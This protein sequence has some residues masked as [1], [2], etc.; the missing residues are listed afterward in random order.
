MYEK[1][2]FIAWRVWFD[3]FKS[4]KIS[5]DQLL[6]NAYRTMIKLEVEDYSR[7]KTL[8]ELAENALK[9]DPP[10]RSKG[11]R[12][13]PETLRQIARELVEMANEEGFIL[14][15][16]ST[17]KTAFE[18]AADILANLGI[19]ATPRQ[20]EDWFYSPKDQLPE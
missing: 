4:G 18:H 15:R 6:R 14:S 8:G 10:K 1:G 19:S 13:Q 5:L 2:R 11:N 20:V 7:W 17:S 12:G 9:V 3:A 16:V